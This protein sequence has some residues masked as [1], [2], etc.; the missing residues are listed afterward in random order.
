MLTRAALIAAVLLLCTP[1]LA[2]AGDSAGD[3]GNDLLEYCKP[4]AEHGAEAKDFFAGYCLGLIQGMRYT[5]SVDVGAHSLAKEPSTDKSIEAK[6]ATMRCDSVWK[7]CVPDEATAGQLA[8][9]VVKFLNDHPE[10]LH[11]DAFGLIHD[12]FKAAFP[13]PKPG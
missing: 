6:R 11:E 8:K 5:M 2:R 10:R 13:C 1:R 4:V 7:E 9:V 3:T 12:A